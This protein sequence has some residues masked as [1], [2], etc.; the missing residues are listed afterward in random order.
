MRNVQFPA[1]EDAELDEEFEQAAKV[2]PEPV[3][4]TYDE[5]AGNVDEWVD[6]WARQVAG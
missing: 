3:T 5:L 4:F 2:P 6:E 1:V